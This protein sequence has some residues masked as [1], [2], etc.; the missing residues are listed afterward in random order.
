MTVSA[1]SNHPE[2]LLGETGDAALQITP[3]YRGTMTLQLAEQGAA[4]A[5]RAFALPGSTTT[6]LELNLP[7]SGI[8]VAL[9]IPSEGSTRLCGVLATAPTPP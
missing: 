6:G 1:A 7:K 4:S 5:T 3:E 8:L 2:V 9:G